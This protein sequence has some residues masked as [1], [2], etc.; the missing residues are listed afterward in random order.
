M[1][2]IVICFYI[3]IYIHREIYIQYNVIWWPLEPPEIQAWRETAREMP[4]HINM[5]IYIYIYI[6]T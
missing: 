1:Y 3:Y 5:C 2:T 6:H 4:D